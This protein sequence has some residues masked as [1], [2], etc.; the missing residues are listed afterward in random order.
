MPR[1][2]SSAPR[3]PSQRVGR[4]DRAEVGGEVAIGQV[5]LGKHRPA[6]GQRQP[7][8]GDLQ[9]HQHRRGVIELAGDRD[10]ARDEIDGRDQ[11][12]RRGQQ[13]GATWCADPV[14]TPQPPGQPPVA[15]QAADERS[16]SVLRE[17]VDRLG[18]QRA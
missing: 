2:V 3:R 8:Q 11:V 13:R 10:E 18:H 1:A 14:R 12:G 17:G 5:R 16:E 9:A 6:F 4:A 7:G 15:R